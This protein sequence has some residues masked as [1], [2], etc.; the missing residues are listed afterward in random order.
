MQGRTQDLGG[1]V[2]II[3]FSN[4]EMQ[5]TWRIARGVRGHAPPPPGDFFKM[6]QLGTFWC[7][8]FIK[9]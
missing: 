2:R 8:F 1:G 7:V 3:F 5:C 9:F 6:V 4:L